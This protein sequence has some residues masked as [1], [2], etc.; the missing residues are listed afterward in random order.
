MPKRKQNPKK[1]PAGKL[2][3]SAVV[4]VSD[5]LKSERARKAGISR[6]LITRLE[7]I[8]KIALVKAG[9][10]RLI[11]RDEIKKV[12]GE[13]KRIDR[14]KKSE[15]KVK[16]RLKWLLNLSPQERVKRFLEANEQRHALQSGLRDTPL[17][18]RETKRFVRLTSLI[19]EIL[20]EE[21]FLYQSLSVG[22]KNIADEQ[23]LQ[24]EIRRI[25]RLH[26]R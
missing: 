6:S 10:E 14:K 18:K 2:P 20:Q 26:S 17:E 25:R 11:G 7:K 13:R 21:R 22:F 15:P 3:F 12:L 24:L 5:F 16:P 23:L 8:G 9:S 4:R 1:R 19:N